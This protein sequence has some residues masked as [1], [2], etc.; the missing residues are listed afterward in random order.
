VIQGHGT[1]GK[2]RRSCGGFAWWESTTA[3]IIS[4]RRFAVRFDP[5][6][7][8]PAYPSA[9]RRREGGPQARALEVYAA[10]AL[11]T[12]AERKACEIRLRAERRAG[13]LLKEMEENVGSHAERG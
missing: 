7:P 3:S 9:H 12:D 6:R 5:A 10:Q 4:A 13:E 11:N 8:Y 1:G 2:R